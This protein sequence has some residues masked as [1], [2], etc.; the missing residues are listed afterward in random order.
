MGEHLFESELCRFLIFLTKKETLICMYTDTLLYVTLSF[1]GSVLAPGTILAHI[2]YLHV[3]PDRRFP[4]SLQAYCLSSVLWLLFWVNLMFKHT[5]C[6]L[7]LF[8]CKIHKDVFVVFNG[9]CWAEASAPLNLVLCC[10]LHQPFG[11]TF[12]GHSLYLPQLQR[13]RPLLLLK[14]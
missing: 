3:L 5:S 4:F 8:Q 10:A 9:S 12:T 13:S 2:T 7:F 1:R 6:F 11:Y 14:F